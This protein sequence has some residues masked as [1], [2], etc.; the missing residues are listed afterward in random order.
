M[1]IY[2]YNIM[3]SLFNNEMINN[4][5]FIVP[6][7]TDVE[8]HQLQKKKVALY[9]RNKYANNPKYTEYKKEQANIKYK[10]MRQYMR[11]TKTNLIIKYLIF[12]KLYK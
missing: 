9:N 2:Y 1:S 5:S 4:K 3:N 11:K 6:T 8:K 10:K 7:L 12:F